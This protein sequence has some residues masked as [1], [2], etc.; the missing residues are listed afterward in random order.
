MFEQVDTLQS[1]CGH[2]SL[3]FLALFRHFLLGGFLVRTRW[4]T[5]TTAAA[6]AT[7]TAFT[8]ARVRIRRGIG[9]GRWT[10]TVATTVRTVRWRSAGWFLAFLGLWRGT[11]SHSRK[12]KGFYY[13]YCCRYTQNSFET[14]S[15]FSNLLRFFFKSCVLDDR[16]TY[17]RLPLHS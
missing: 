7:G 14:Y 5:T 13:S 16:W 3:F 15:L 1:S 11:G 2:S 8:V 10:A 17:L 6:A 4:A 12:F 9:T